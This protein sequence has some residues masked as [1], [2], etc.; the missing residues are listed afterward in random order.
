MR[1]LTCVALV[2]FLV[3]SP[4][5]TM[6]SAPAPAASP[7]PA[8]DTTTVVT[9]SFVSNE[10]TRRLELDTVE[11]QGYD[12]PGLD[13][14]AAVSVNRET[15]DSG[16]ELQLLSVRLAA[17]SSDAEREALVET[18]IAEMESRVDTL[19]RQERQAIEAYGTGELSKAQ[20]LKQLAFVG[21]RAEQTKETIR[22]L[23]RST[24]ISL[25]YVTRQANE[26]SSPARLALYQRMFDGGSEQVAVQVRG[27]QS[28]VVLQMLVEAG[29][30]T[31]YYREAVRLD[32]LDPDSAEG[33]AN[34][35]EFFEYI[36]NRYP[37]VRQ[38]SG[39]TIWEF[40]RGSWFYE[41]PLDQGSIRIY[42]DG[43][44]QNVYREY[45]RLT[46][47][48]LPE[49][50][51]FNATDYG[52]EVVINETAN[53]GPARIQVQNVLTD[54]PVAAPV[55]VGDTT[56]GQTDEDGV[57]WYAQPKGTY[58]VTVELPQGPINVTVTPSQSP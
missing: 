24:G 43:S 9:E 39:A 35:S 27:S 40:K 17:A 3:L 6:A 2:A 23:E 54:D 49:S 13:F 12:S 31:E 37:Y 29:P 15:V 53:G 18:A 52:V 41:S 26:Y 44:Q 51:S 34:R 8:P 21:H 46:V 14:G 28:G 33:F 7:S 19:E 16:Y 47:S 50:N 32:H 36:E 22:R 5:G 55:T 25:G 38:S 45:Q 48:S 11:R 4:V 58:E 10:T 20:L 56:I 42:V 1:R 57:L 30:D